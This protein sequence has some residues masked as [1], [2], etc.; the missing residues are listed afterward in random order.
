LLGGGGGGGGFWRRGKQGPRR[1]IGARAISLK[2]RVVSRIAERNQSC[3]RVLTSA[4]R[5]GPKQWK[6]TM[7]KKKCEK[8]AGKKRGEK[9]SRSEYQNAS[10]EE[11]NE[12]ASGKELRRGGGLS[13]FEG[14]HRRGTQ[15]NIRE[16]TTGTP[17][18]KQ[19]YQKSSTGN[20]WGN[21]KEKKG[22]KRR[23]H[24]HAG[25]QGDSLSGKK[26]QKTSCRTPGEG[27]TPPLNGEASMSVESDLLR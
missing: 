27:K 17:D 6:R 10:W 16:K 20:L 11:S 18:I 24:A 14:K 21:L 12:R 8:N 5:A 7:D 23:Q 1:A 4:E 15:H 13:P 2:K 9:V 3:G 22:K 25:R 26:G 19:Q